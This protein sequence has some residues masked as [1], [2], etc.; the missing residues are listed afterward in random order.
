MTQVYNKERH[1]SILSRRLLSMYLFTALSGIEAHPPQPSGRS[2]GDPRLPI[3]YRG[4]KR[5][6]EGGGKGKRGAQAPGRGTRLGG[7]SGTEAGER[8]SPG[9]G[10]VVNADRA[11][12]E[13]RRGAAPRTSG[14]LGD[15]RGLGRVA[16][17][18][19]RPGGQRF[20]VPTPASANKPD[21]VLER[22]SAR[23]RIWRA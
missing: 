6:G 15:G 18:A 20:A 23:M 16:G 14:E 10:D 17:G 4:G 11:W 9:A 5:N 1:D 19:F 22:P 7:A 3:P 21:K 2:G 8:R 12:V 13:F